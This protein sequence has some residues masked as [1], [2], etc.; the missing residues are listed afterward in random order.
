MLTGEFGEQED[1]V[2]GQQ[3]VELDK[4]DMLTVRRE[5]PGLTDDEARTLYVKAAEKAYLKQETYKENYQKMF[6]KVMQICDQNV[7]DRL[8]RLSDFTEVRV[9]HDC[10]RLWEMICSVVRRRYGTQSG[11]AEV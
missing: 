2:I 5:F 4:P 7:K 10:I 3:A 6:G 9:G 8:F 11:R 1:F